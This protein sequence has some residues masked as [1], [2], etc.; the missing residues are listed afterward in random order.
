MPDERVCRPS[1]GHGLAMGAERFSA[2]APT[3]NRRVVGQGATMRLTFPVAI[4][5]TVGAA[6]AAPLS[7]VPPQRILIVDDDPLVLKS[8]RDA[9]ES[10]GHS[11]TIADGGQA[12][13]DAFLAARTRNE[14]FPVVI[15]DLGIPHVD[16]RRVS[17][18]I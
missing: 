12:G 13:I 3:S 17:S 5:G 18:A 10:D 1:C 15:T 2:T 7:A 16:G 11:V 14:P 9:L 8:V 4:A 6:P